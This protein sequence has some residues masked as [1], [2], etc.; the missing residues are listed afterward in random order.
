MSPGA[1]VKLTVFR[2]G[3]TREIAVKLGETPAG[4]GESAGVSEPRGTALRGIS[5]TALTPDTASQL[6]LP[7][8]TKGV[9]VSNVDAAGAASEAG[10]EQGCHSGSESPA[11]YGLRRI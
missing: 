2:T 1:T 8:G 4:A 11:G 9:V 3:A 10:L 7:A 5:V 6:K